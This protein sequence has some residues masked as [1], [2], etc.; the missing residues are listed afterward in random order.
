LYLC[1]IVN[2]NSSRFWIGSVSLVK[3]PFSCYGYTNLKT[4]SGNRLLL[5]SGCDQ[6]DIAIHDISAINMSNVPGNNKGIDLAGSLKILTFNTID[7]PVPQS[8][9]LALLKGHKNSITDLKWCNDDNST[10]IASASEDNFVII[11][12][13]LTG[14]TRALFNRHRSRVLS[15]CWNISEPNVLFSGSEDRFIY[16]WNL[17]DFPCK[18]P[19]QCK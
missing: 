4:D 14:E 16:E 8:E 15:V 5:A 13:G 11:W 7:M 12:D 3:R 17:D 10:L 18:E 1:Q 6:G 2:D 9:A 19:I